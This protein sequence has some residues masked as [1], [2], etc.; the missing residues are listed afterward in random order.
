MS[1][2]L[3][4]HDSERSTGARQGKELHKLTT[5]ARNM[6]GNDVPKELECL[7]TNKPPDTSKIYVQ[8]YTP[9]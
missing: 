7:F 2:A 9:N 3:Q 6:L 1:R 5:L 4:A 8:P